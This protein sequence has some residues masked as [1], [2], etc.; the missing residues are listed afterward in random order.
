MLVGHN[1]G[2][3][4]RTLIVGE[5]P[6]WRKLRLV[7]LADSP[8]SFRA[9]LSEERQQPDE[10]WE[11][12]IEPTIAHPRG[13]LW[14]A[15]LDGDSVGMVFARIDSEFSLVGIGAMWVSPTVRGQG[16]GAGLLSSPLDWAR[17][18]GVRLAELWVT[19]SNTSAELFYERFGF[20]VEGDGFT[21][22]VGTASI[23]M[24]LRFPA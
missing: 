9:T 4:I 8:D 15:E 13:N 7:A 16:I 2:V 23:T 24:L 21:N 12:L 1:H 22:R 19:E 11:N 17:S 5:W 10:W 3:E 6:L 18:Q 20:Q 14:I